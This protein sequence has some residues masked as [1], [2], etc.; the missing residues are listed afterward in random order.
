MPRVVRVLGEDR[1][2][3]EASPWTARALAAEISGGVG[4]HGAKASAAVARS[5][6]V[7]MPGPGAPEALPDHAEP[8]DKTIADHTE[9][10]T[11]TTEGEDA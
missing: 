2:L 4:L 1:S 9:P 7:G 6:A 8:L 11:A 5:G 10:G 3:G